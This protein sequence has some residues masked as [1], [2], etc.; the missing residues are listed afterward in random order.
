MGMSIHWHSRTSK[1]TKSTIK[2]Q[3][4]FSTYY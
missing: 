3:V 2:R 1:G 4:V